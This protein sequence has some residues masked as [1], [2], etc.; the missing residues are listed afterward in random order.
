M[1]VNRSEFS[2]FLGAFDACHRT[3]PLFTPPRTWRLTV[4]KFG[5]TRGSRNYR[6]S[7]LTLTAQPPTVIAQF[8]LELQASA[9]VLISSPAYAHGVPGG[10]KNALDW[11]VGSG[12]IV[13][14][15]VPR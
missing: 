10:L 3:P 2:Q 5:S 1:G 4:W 7:T 13:G 15:R 11:I 14:K 8:R 12:E 9:A 6:C